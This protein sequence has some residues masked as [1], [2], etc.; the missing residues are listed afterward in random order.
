MCGARRQQLTGVPLAKTKTSYLAQLGPREL[1][2]RPTH[3]I[4]LRSLAPAL[5]PPPKRPNSGHDLSSYVPSL[6]LLPAATGL[7]S[8]SRHLSIF[9]RPHLSPSHRPTSCPHIR[10]SVL[11]TGCKHSTA[12]SIR[13]GR[14]SNYDEWSRYML[15]QPHLPYFSSNTVQL[16]QPVAGCPS[17]LCNVA[18]ATSHGQAGAA[19]GAVAEILQ[20]AR[21]K[22]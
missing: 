20:A 10:R 2:S 7:V 22:Y 12:R 8:S 3:R 1:A 9:A 4:R 6:M 13:G 18:Q 16:G 21:T 17:C 19:F 15:L 14:K 5:T 11:K